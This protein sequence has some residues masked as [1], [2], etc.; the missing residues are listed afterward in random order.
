MFLIM[1]LRPIRPADRHPSLRGGAER[2]KNTTAIKLCTCQAP[3]RPGW[4]LY[5]GGKAKEAD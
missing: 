5:Y 1:R 2:Q 3:G 4:V